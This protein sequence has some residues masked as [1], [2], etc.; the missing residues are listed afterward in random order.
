VELL[1]ATRSAGKMRE[2]RRILA[3]VPGVRVIDLDDA[4]VA[5]DR[6]E[7]ALEPYDTFEENA[8]S[9]AAYFMEKTGLPTVAD[10]S[11]LEVDALGGAPG[12]HSARYA[13][14]TA[15]DEANCRKLLQALAGV[16][17]EGRTARFR[18]VI[19]VVRQADDAAPIVAEAC[20]AGRIAEAP[21]GDGGFGYDPVFVDLDTGRTAAEL[22][23]AVKNAV[24]HRARALREL[25][26]RLEA[27]LDGP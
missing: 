2:I 25:R 3:G 10:D 15:D 27:G 17:P 4:G 12:V 13:G 9:K 14:P 26:A 16:S 20:W 11:G 19:A 8:R 21:R 22:P 23:A 5:Y 7:E 1:V 24:S 6:A 18:C